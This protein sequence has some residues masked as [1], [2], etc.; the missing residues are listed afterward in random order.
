LEDSGR[1]VLIFDDKPLRRA[2]YVCLLTAWAAEQDLTIVGH[3][4][5]DLSVI[6]GNSA[7]EIICVGSRSVNELRLRPEL[8]PENRPFPPVVVISDLDDPSEIASALQLGAQ[9]FV[10][11]AASPELA[12]NTMTFVMSGGE[13]FPVSVLQTPEK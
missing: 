9:G 8:S 11:T 3:S 12:V 6:D 10:P 5:V 7:L 4:I 2:A 13:F 1:M